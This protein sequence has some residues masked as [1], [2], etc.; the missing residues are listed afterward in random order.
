MRARRQLAALLGLAV[1]TVACGRSANE[2]PVE[3][4]R[5]FLD[6]MERGA[7]EEDALQEAY[8]LM[9][10]PARA[11]LA[12]RAARAS[13]LSGRSFQPWQMLARGRFRRRFAPGTRAGM[14][15]RIDGD[16]AVVTVSADKSGPRA[17]V[18]LVR[19]QGHWRIRLEIPPMR[20]APEGARQP[21][22]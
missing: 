9:D 14:H 22:G 5:H 3:T 1:L 2:S 8:S 20:E 15:E 6:A 13:A 19:E 21:G 11:A 12:R 17:D 10:A 16:H 18:P 4:V 7:D